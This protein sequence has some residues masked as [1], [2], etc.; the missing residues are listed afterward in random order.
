MRQLHRLNPDDSIY[1]FEVDRGDASDFT[2]Q[3]QVHGRREGDNRILQARS[4]VVANSFAALLMYL[5]RTTG[6][7][8][9]V[10]FHWTDV[11]PVTTVMALFFWAKATP[12]R[13]PM[14]CFAGQSKTRRNARLC[15]SARV[16]FRV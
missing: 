9:H 5:E 7:I 16:S 12:H 14:R 3:L 15:T 11:N 6:C 1:F 8:P 10:Y 4:A 13:S 2:G